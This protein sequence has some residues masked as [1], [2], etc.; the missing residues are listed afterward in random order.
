MRFNFWICIFSKLIWFVSILELLFLHFLLLKTFP[1]S[2]KILWYIRLHIG[3][4]FN[5]GMRLLL[6]HFSSLLVFLLGRWLLRCRSDNWSCHWYISYRSMI[7]R[8][9]VLIIIVGGSFLIRLLFAILEAE[10]IGSIL[11]FDLWLILFPLLFTFSRCDIFVRR[12]IFLW[13]I[14]TWAS[15]GL[16]FS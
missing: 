5:I 3:L 14:L 13:R 15:W 2:W 9:N 11:R 6:F 4:L 10:W 12:L 1:R 16:C 7:V 8:F